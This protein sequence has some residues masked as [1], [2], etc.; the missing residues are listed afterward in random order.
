METGSAVVIVIVGIAIEH[1]VL[2]QPAADIV[3]LGVRLAGVYL[4]PGA[5]FIE[6][7]TEGNAMGDWRAAIWL[8]DRRFPNDWSLKWIRRNLAAEQKHQQQ[9]HSIMDPEWRELIR[10]IDQH[11]RAITKEQEDDIRDKA[12]NGPG[13]LP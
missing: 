8:L 4:K 9:E 5:E 3:F 10:A 11:T 13:S 6:I 1:V 12:W 7:D 2:A